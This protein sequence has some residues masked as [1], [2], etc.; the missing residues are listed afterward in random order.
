MTE[1][2]RTLKQM[3][4]E[5]I[6]SYSRSLTFSREP[7]I[8]NDLAVYGVVYGLRAEE[9]TSRE[10]EILQ[11][12]KMAIVHLTDAKRMSAARRSWG[13]LRDESENETSPG[14]FLKEKLKEKLEDRIYRRIFGED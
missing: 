9:L 2:Y 7:E 3:I 4:D 1:A 13:H 14:E 5:M 6:I 12:K 8:S 10:M 11:S